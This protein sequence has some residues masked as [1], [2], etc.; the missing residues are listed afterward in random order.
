MQYLYLIGGKF[1]KVRA[2][3]PEP[4]WQQTQVPSFA[5]ELAL[6]MARGT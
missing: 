1:V 6:R 2:T 5:R 3:I 4:G